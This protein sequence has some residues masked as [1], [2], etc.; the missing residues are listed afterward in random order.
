M[1]LKDIGFKNVQVSSDFGESEVKD[2]Q[3]VGFSLLK[4]ED[5]MTNIYGF[6]AEFNPFHNGH[7]LFIDSINKISP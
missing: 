4:I 5:L 3:P 2:I 6:I 7:K 1:I